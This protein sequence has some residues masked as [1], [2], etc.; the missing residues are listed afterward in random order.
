MGDIISKHISDPQLNV[1]YLAQILNISRVNLYK[2]CLEVFNKKPSDYI[3]EK[4]INKSI[5]LL[6]TDLNISEVAY[7]SGFTSPA[8][9]SK[10]FTSLKGI[11]PKDFKKLI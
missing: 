1:N 10:V 3:I 9:F 7:Q 2:K 4:R 8:Y 6:K 5:F 11:N